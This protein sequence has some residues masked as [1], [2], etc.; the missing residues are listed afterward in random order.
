MKTPKTFFILTSIFAALLSSPSFGLNRPSEIVS[1]EV[2]S[3]GGYEYVNI[4][5]DSFAPPVQNYDQA[6]H[7]L[8]LTFYNSTIP[9]PLDVSPPPESVIS[10]I[11]TS[12]INT[13][14]SYVEMVISLKAGIRYDVTNLIGRNQTMIEMKALQAAPVE[15]KPAA[16]EVPVVTPVATKE[17]EKPKEKERITVKVEELFAAAPSSL[18][19]LRKGKNLKTIVNGLEFKMRGYPAFSGAVLMVPAIDFFENLGAQT[20]VISPGMLSVRMGDAK[21]VEINTAERTIKVNGSK[22]DLA[23][24]PYS[25]KKFGREIFYVPLENAAGIVDYKVAWDDRD[26]VVVVDPILNDVSSRG[27][28]KAYFVD[29]FFSD[30]LDKDRIF[31]SSG[32]GLITVEAKDVLMSSKLKKTVWIGKGEVLKAVLGEAGARNTRVTLMLKS[33][34]PFRTSYSDEE[35]EFSLFF[36]PAIVGIKAVK[37]KTSTKINISTDAPMTFEASSSPQGIILQ[38]PGMMLS[39][40]GKIDA[41]GGVIVNVNASQ[42][43]VDPPS[44]K[45]SVALLEKAAFKIFVSADKKKLSLVVTQPK[46]LMAKKPKKNYSALKD[47]I[48]VI[49]PGHGGRDPGTIGFSGTYEKNAN[50]AQSLEIARALESAGATVLLTRD[51]DRSMHMKDVVRFASDNKADIF[52]AVHYNS[53]M[54]PYVT[55]TETYY[56]T[57]ESRMLARVIHRN[58]VNGIRRRD[59]GIKRVMYYAIHHSTMPAILV[60]PG[61][62]TNRTEEKLAFSASFQKEVASDILKGVAEYFNMMKRYRR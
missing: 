11:S 2:S 14:P 18:P 58:L 38:F 30:F 17:A 6:D 15:N 24:A 45:L 37:E 32:G 60:E 21:K 49:D 46:K 29:L 51:T 1:I 40:Q 62:I 16:V 25:V 36:S 22:I 61:Y 52:I 28:D 56:F 19:D 57:P 9:S 47:K 41:S 23:A 33:P 31:T 12:V 27:D 8:V 42:A 59:R 48:I 26:N 43:S 50:L 20:S 3:S 34:R 53:F 39:A 7:K 13:D 35:K 4:K 44:V 54:S 55:G 10:S 5:A